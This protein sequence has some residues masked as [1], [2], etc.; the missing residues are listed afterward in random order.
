V[1][2]TVSTTGPV[3]TAQPAALEATIAK[4]W[5]EF[6]SSRTP[7]DQRA[8][9]LEDGFRPALV[10]RAGDPLQSQASARVTGVMLTAPDRATVVYDLLLGG[11]PAVSGSQGVAILQ[12]GIWKVSGATFCGLVTLDFKGPIPGCT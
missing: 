4:N 10:A 5:E 8:T 1:V 9:L 11:K 12:G 2:T 3:T 7:L 6:F